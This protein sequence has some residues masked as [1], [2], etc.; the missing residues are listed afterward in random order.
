MFTFSQ[1]CSILLSNSFLMKTEK[2][3]PH[4]G[5]WTQWEKQPTDRCTDCNQLLDE[6]TLIEKTEREQR[7][8]VYQENDFLRIRETDGLGMRIVRK[9]AWFFHFIF[10]AITWLFLWTV[11]TFSG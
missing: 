6:I 8:L 5:I 7:E 9:T 3:C 2:K 10:A 1:N 11:T 4:C